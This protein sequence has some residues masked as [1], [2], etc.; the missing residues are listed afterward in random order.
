MEIDN[1]FIKEKLETSIISTSFVPTTE[2]LAN[3]LTKE[4]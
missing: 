2:Q 1:H 3:I 4:I